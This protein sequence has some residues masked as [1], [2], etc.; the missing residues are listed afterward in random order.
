MKVL[1]Y[2]RGSSLEERIVAG[3]VG[4]S[5]VVRE[6]GDREEITPHVD[7]ACKGR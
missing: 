5:S 7:V 2:L 4:N 6:E 1:K 3:R